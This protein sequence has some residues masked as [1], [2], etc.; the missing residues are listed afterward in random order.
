[1]IAKN[2]TQIELSSRE[3]TEDLT[4]HT[5]PAKIKHIPEF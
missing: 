1:M 4:S 5:R 2:W 3:R